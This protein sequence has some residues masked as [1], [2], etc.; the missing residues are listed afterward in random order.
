MNWAGFARMSREEYD[1]AIVCFDVRSRESFDESKN[2]LDMLKQGDGGRLKHV[3]ALGN[4]IDETD[5]RIVSTDAAQG[6]F[7]G[8][9]PPVPYFEASA[10]TNAG[11]KEVFEAVVRLLLG[12]TTEDQLM[13]G[14]G[15]NQ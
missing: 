4:C 12:H 11:V 6:Y 7:S 13:N 5:K 9:N 1:A 3:V 2:F 15:N 14:N 10:K 8:L